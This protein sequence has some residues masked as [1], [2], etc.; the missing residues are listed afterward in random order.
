[1]VFGFCFYYYWFNGRRLLARPLTQFLGRTQLNFPF[2]VCW[3]N[4]T[5]SRYW[6]GQEREALIKQE[7]PA[8][9][10]VKFIRDIIPILK[11]PRY[12]KVQGA[13]LLMVY[14][15]S[16]PPNPSATAEIWRAE[17]RR[18]GIPSV[19]LVA[20]QSLGVGDP[21]PFGFDAAVE[22]PPDPRRIPTDRGS[23]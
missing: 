10:S 4:E 22:F 21:R 11:D 7:Y 5:W 1:N 6:R 20:V 12:I 23:L 19:H 8:D 9:F 15:V 2:S 3:A 14:G 17:C 16:L 13:P 18:A